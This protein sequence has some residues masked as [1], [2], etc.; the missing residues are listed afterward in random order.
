MRFRCVLIAAFGLVLVGCTTYRIRVG[1]AYCIKEVH[2]ISWEAGGSRALYFREPGGSEVQ[3]WGSV[4]AVQARDNV[5]VF[6]GNTQPGKGG[7]SRGFFAVEGSGPLL[8]IEKALWA[9]QADKER[10]NIVEFINRYSINDWYLK[11]LTNGFEL[12][13]SLSRGVNSTNFY[14]SITWEELSAIMRRVRTEGTLQKDRSGKLY[15]QIQSAK[16]EK[17]NL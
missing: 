2:G 4:G 17:R 3:I 5:A 14:V 16:P 12:Q 1:G 8:E 10:V 7:H 13:S 9:F 6:M 11:R 15:L